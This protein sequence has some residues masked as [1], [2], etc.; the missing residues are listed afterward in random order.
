MVKCHHHKSPSALLGSHAKY[1]ISNSASINIVFQEFQVKS[2][3][4][5]SLAEVDQQFMEHL[6][7]VPVVPVPPP[8]S[9]YPGAC[10]PAFFLFLFLV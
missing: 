9:S 7:L 3:E 1:Q 5:V 10:G 6:D 2:S 8:P 4:C